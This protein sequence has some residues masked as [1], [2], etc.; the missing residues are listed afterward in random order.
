M[1]RDNKALKLTTNN[2]K[3]KQIIYDFKINIARE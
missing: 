2:M 1:I 3:T